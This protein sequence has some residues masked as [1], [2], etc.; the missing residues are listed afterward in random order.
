MQ[1]LYYCYLTEEEKNSAK[2]H[3]TLL[4]SRPWGEEDVD[5]KFQQ[6]QLSFQQQWLYCKGSHLSIWHQ[7]KKLI[8]WSQAILLRHIFH[9]PHLRRVLHFAII[10]Q[11]GKKKLGL[12]FMF[13]KWQPLHF[14]IN[15]VNISL[16]FSPPPWNNNF[17]CL[18]ANPVIFTTEDSQK[19][20][21][22]SN[23]ATTITIYNYS[24]TNKTQFVTLSQKKKYTYLYFEVICNHLNNL[25]SL[26]E[27]RKSVAH[28]H[29]EKKTTVNHP[30]E[31]QE[32]IAWFCLI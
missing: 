13:T 24:T 6:H 27:E 9:F 7:R 21:F 29:I 19:I 5:C 26:W 14:R 1:Q 3:K 16:S 15:L 18:I 30:E 31:R 11:T 28:S 17:L 25:R 10:I 22:I 2:R 4:Q 12:L 8:L 20:T 32:N 23:T